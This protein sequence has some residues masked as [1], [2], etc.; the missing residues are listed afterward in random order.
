MENQETIEPEETEEKPVE[1]KAELKTGGAVAAIVPQDIEQTFRMAQMIVKSGMAPKD[2]NR[3]EQ[4]VAAI[5]TGLEV[6]LKPMQS[7]QSIAVINGRPTIWG[8]GALGLVHASGKLEDFSETIEGEGLEMLARCVAKRFDMSTPIERT[9]SAQ[10]AQKAGLWSKKGPWSTYPKR[11]LQMRAR[12]WVL[13]DGFADIL[14]G[15]GIAEEIRDYKEIRDITPKVTGADITAQLDTPSQLE[16]GEA[17]E[18][19]PGDF[20]GKE[21]NP[22]EDQKV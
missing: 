21:I 4:I 7:L 17:D 19:E 1:H 6:G 22:T 5:T 13:R 8:D 11:M 18:A 15:L 14:K 2:M 9:F 16:P 3:P 10:D 20:F 12:S